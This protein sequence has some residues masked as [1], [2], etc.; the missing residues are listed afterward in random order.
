M[1]FGNRLREL[2]RSKNLTQK[3][4]A[5]E[6]NTSEANISR[7]ESSKREPR[8]DFV[9][10]VSEYFDVTIDYLL[11][12]SDVKQVE[13]VNDD[14]QNYSLF[15]N[16]TEA[17]EFI[18]RQPNLMHWCGYDLNKLTDDEVIEFAN[19]VLSYL[20]LLSFKYKK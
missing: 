14:V 12:K 17:I 16:P 6:L 10:S 15:K 4:L 18:I 8:G 11:G 5:L 3:Q 1:S 9:T 7:Y 20:K 2:R 19:E 13:C